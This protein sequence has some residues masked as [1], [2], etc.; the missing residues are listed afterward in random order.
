M[1][2]PLSVCVIQCLKFIRKDTS[3]KNDDLLRLLMY[4]TERDL[5][6]NI[7]KRLVAAKEW[8]CRGGQWT[9]SL[10]LAEAS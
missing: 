9:G 1:V 3:L 7:E 2:C 6:Q 5:K 8:R 4:E 10:G